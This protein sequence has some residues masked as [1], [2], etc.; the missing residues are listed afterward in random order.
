MLTCNMYIS[1]SGQGSSARLWHCW[2]DGEYCIISIKSRQIR[3]WIN[4]CERIKNSENFLSLFE[5][6]YIA[7]LGQNV[8]SLIE[9]PYRAMVPG[10]GLKSFVFFLKCK[11][12]GLNKILFYCLR[13]YNILIC[14]RQQM[15]L[16]IATASKR[17][18]FMQVSNSC[19]Q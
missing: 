16:D 4:I 14:K 11:F 15:L 18:R 5:I 12:Q 3:Y 1:L 2:S 8:P 19:C 6:F 17:F 10:Q 9:Y 7:C 13:I